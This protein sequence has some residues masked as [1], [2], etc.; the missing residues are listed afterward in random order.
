[1]FSIP[2]SPKLANVLAE[3][4]TG[5]FLRYLRHSQAAAHISPESRVV[6]Q[7]L[8]HATKA[9]LVGS[10]KKTV[11]IIVFLLVMILTCGLA[12]V[13]ENVRPAVIVASVP[14]RAPEAPSRSEQSQPADQ[15]AGKKS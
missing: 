7:I 3:R 6:I 2:T 14:T 1:M 12:L 11:P 5:K 15:V 9:T 8:N 10:R 4:A 13:L